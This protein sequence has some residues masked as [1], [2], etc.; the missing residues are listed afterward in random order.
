ML[1][2]FNQGVAWGL[3]GGVGVDLIAGMPLGA[4]SLGLMS[5]CFLAGLGKSSVFASNI[6]LPMLIVALATPLNG[7][8]IRLA[9]Q[10]LGFPVNWVDTTVRVIGPEMLLNAVTI[11]VTY[12]LLRWFAGTFGPKP[13]GW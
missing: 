6:L 8:V 11:T 7:W 9:Q 2:G 4:S 13:M 1:S 5:T 10:I 3:V 12:P